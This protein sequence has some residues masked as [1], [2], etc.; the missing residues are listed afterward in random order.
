MSK[1]GVQ[2]AAAKRQLQVEG[3]TAF[4]RA[5]SVN[6]LDWRLERLMADVRKE[7]DIAQEQH[8][9]IV[10]KVMSE[11]AGAAIREGKLPPKPIAPAPAP[12]PVPVPPPAEAHPTPTGGKGKKR[13]MDAPL[14][15]AMAPI[16]PPA[17]MMA[18][19]AALPKKGKKGAAAAAAAVAAAAAAAADSAVPIPTGPLAPG[20]NKWVGRVVERAWEGAWHQAVVTDFNPVTGLHALSYEYGSPR[21]SFE[22]YSCDRGPRSQFRPTIRAVD[23]KPII[24]RLAAAGKL[25]VPMPMSVPVPV[26]SQQQARDPRED[27]PIAPPRGGKKKGGTPKAPA[28]PK[29]ADKDAEFLAKVGAAN[30]EELGRMSAQL[31]TEEARVM[32]EMIEIGDTDDDEGEEAALARLTAEWQ[33]LS[34]R[35]SEIRRELQAL[36]GA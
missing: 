35:E 28:G 34:S 2:V 19:T 14:P 23:I 11:P 3:Y 22:W 12:M 13:K 29:A 36:E 18:P 27:Q 26:P 8:L 5:L 24:A 32:A 17:P 20:L 1:L 15:P 25:A 4:I 16:Q 10:E 21:E 9:E 7:L 6:N 30:M 31:R 33:K